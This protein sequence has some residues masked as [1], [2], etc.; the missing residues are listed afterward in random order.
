MGSDVSAYVDYLLARPGIQRHHL[1]RQLVSLS[2]KIPQ[3]VFVQ[4]VARA[5]RY[6][7][8]GLETL[9]RIAWFCLSQNG[10]DL[11]EVDIDE[12]YRQRAAYLEGYIT[13]EPD[14]SR[15]DEPLSGSDD[16]GL[17]EGEV[18]DVG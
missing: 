1:L 6:R 5:L 12:E 4:A 8:A 17:P 16:Q 15:Y 14:L 2:Q 9:Q 7:V 18:D 10:L 3:E 11:P 13:D